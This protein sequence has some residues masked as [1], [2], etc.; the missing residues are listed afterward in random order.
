MDDR[1]AN[2]IVGRL[3]NDKGAIQLS[4]RD[5]LI[6]NFIVLFRK[7][8]NFIV[9]TVQFLCKSFSRASTHLLQY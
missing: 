3:N 8:F 6:D 4:P 1:G 5:S 9:L 2:V 7:K